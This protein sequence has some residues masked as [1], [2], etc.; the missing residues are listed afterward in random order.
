MSDETRQG[1]TRRD[2]LRV[3]GATFA[4]YALAPDATLAQVVKIDTAGLVAG[5]FQVKIGDYSM[6]VYEARPA[7]G[8]DHPIILV[9]SEIWG[10]HEYIRDCTRR[11]AKA[12]YYAV[13][14]ELFQRAGGTAHLTNIQDILKIV[15]A[16]PREQTLGDLKAA[17]DW[18]K[19]RPG[20]KADRVG[21]NGWCW[22]GST[23]IQVAAA[24]PDVKAA[25]AWYGPPGRPYQSASGPITGF[26]VVK[27][28]KGP[29]LGLFGEKDTN[30]KPEDAVRFGDL[31]KQHNPR[32]DVVLFPAGHGFHADYRQ[33]YDPASAG[34][35]WKMCLEF[36]EK[37]LKT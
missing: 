9:I 37:N 36:F 5:D 31:L 32:T 28:I 30:P 4:G 16:Q 18:A 24:N 21:A 25:V 26:D 15:L 13:A 3:G 1:L 17:V 2:L 22:G 12:G 27:D 20:V 14:P 33:S 23:T 8:K 10:V 11:F 29:F 6:P 19:K 34:Q 7:S 35:A